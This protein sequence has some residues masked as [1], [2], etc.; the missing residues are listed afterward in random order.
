MFEKRRS[1]FTWSACAVSVLVGSIAAG[2]AMQ[3][4]SVP[5]DPG[6]R[7]GA[8]GAGGPIAGLTLKEGKFFATGQDAF[9][10]VQSVQGAIA[11]TE[12]GLGPRFNL[13]SCGGCHSQPATGGTS[14]SVNPQVAVAHKNGATNTV[15]SFI[16]INGP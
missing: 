12:P 5:A 8:P 15:P 1:F 7:G 3:L 2:A 11:G 9:V 4:T 6:V 13:D 10:E 16:S 14:P